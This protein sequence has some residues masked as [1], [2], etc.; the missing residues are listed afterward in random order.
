MRS[1]CNRTR[2][3]FVVPAKTTTATFRPARFCWY[4]ILRSVVSKR[5]TDADSAAFNKAPLL[6][7]SQPL[8]LAV[9]TVWPRSALARPRGV[10]WQK[11]GSKRMSIDGGGVLRRRRY[12]EALRHKIEHGGNL[13]PRHV[14][15]FHHFFDGQILKVLD[16]CSNGQPRI[17]KHPRAANLARDALHGGA[18]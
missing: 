2:D 7:L 10:P 18:L 13:L 4:R 8:A 5:S 15:L 6:S 3:H 12:V 14:E 17:L 1:R 11:T 9:T 16:H